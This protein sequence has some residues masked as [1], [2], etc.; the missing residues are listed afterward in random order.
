MDVSKAIKERRAYR[1]LKETNIDEGLIK[2]LAEHAS[3]APSCFNNQPWKFIFV[4]ET[5]VLNEVKRALSKG[6]KWAYNASMIIAVI[7]KEEDDCV[8]GNRKYYL[9]DTGM[10]VF[11]LILRATE[12]GYVAHP[13]AGYNPQKVKDALDIPDDMEVIALLIF[14]QHK[15]EIDDL[16]PEKQKEAEIRRPKRKPFEEFSFINKYGL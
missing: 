2:D 14:G 15:E 6:N 7:S 3:L 12:L 4:Y 10:A 5:K 13:I 1:S 9:F 8:I 16:L 11:S